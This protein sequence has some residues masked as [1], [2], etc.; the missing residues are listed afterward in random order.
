[1][2]YVET[3]RAKRMIGYALIGLIMLW[4][5]P[6]L[7]GWVVSGKPQ[8]IQYSLADRICGTIP[9]CEPNNETCQQIA[10]QVATCRNV[11]INPVTLLQAIGTLIAILVMIYGAIKMKTGE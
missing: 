3:A 4:L 11:V 5:A 10:Q 1:M 7:V 2:S 9:S 6:F 8:L